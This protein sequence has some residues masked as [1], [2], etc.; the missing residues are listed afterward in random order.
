MITTILIT[1]FF[2]ELKQIYHADRAT[3]SG[4]EK[5][6]HL[7]L[8]RYHTVFNLHLAHT[9]YCVGGDRTRLLEGRAACARR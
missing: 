7:L 9:S 6:V 8:R 3:W 4:R 1:G 2:P 5:A